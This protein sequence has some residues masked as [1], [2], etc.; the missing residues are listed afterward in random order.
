MAIDYGEFRIRCTKSGGDTLRGVSFNENDE[1]DLCDDGDPFWFHGDWHDA[2]AICYG[3]P[4]YELCTKID[5][6]EWSVVTSRKPAIPARIAFSNSSI[7]N[8]SDG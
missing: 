1:I 6:G 8:G 5:A 3:G 4:S 2:S 7:R